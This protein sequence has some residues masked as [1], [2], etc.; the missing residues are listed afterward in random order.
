MTRVLR[1][2]SR[3]A[4]SRK[5]SPSFSRSARVS[6]IGTPKKQLAYRHAA[7]APAGVPGRGGDATAQTVRRREEFAT[8]EG[9]TPA[10]ARQRP[11]A[12]GRIP[13]TA[14]TSGRRRPAS[15]IDQCPACS[16][17]A[18]RC[19]KWPDAGRV[20]RRL[21]DAGVAGSAD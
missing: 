7:R 18:T 19:R 5:A 17:C 21:T 2:A 10:P 9:R 12:N 4:S 15:R 6:A 13:A 8:T 16:K 14:R 20:K 3:R 11:M 1:F